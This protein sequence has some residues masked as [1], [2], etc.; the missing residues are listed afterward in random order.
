[1]R[2][3][4]R[5]ARALGVAVLLGMAFWIVDSVITYYYFGESLRFMMFEKPDTLFDAIVFNLSRHTLFVRISFLIACIISGFVLKA[6]APLGVPSFLA[7]HAFAYGGIGMIT[8]GMMARVA[9]GHTGRNVFAP[10]ASL[11]FVFSILFVGVLCRV[12]L[13]LLM[14]DNYPLWIGISQVLWII[15]FALFFIIYLP[16]LIK[17]RIDGSFG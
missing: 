12:L 6:A 11:S 17:P 15:A 3:L 14:P 9:L 1:M 2:G 13:P 16:M 10:P 5:T 4:D 7:L 8:L